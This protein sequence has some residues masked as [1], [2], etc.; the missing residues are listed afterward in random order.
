MIKTVAQ[1]EVGDQFKMNVEDKTIFTFLGREQ[2]GG[3]GANTLDTVWARTNWNGT[4]KVSMVLGEG[5]F[6]SVVRTA[7]VLTALGA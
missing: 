3:R 7:R 6:V 1:L 4:G 2:M 5:Q